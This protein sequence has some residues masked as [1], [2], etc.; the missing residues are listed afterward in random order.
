MFRIAVLTVLS[1]FGALAAS[2][3]TLSV[4]PYPATQ[5][6]E[7]K[8][9]VP[10]KFEGSKKAVLTITSPCGKKEK[11][12]VTI[13]SGKAFFN[14]KPAATG[15]YTME[16]KGADIA[17]KREVPA[18][19]RKMYFYGWVVPRTA[20]ELAKVPV[21]GSCA[22][23]VGGNKEK[24]D[25]YRSYGCTP[26][27]FVSFRAAQINLKTPVDKMVDKMVEKWRKPLEKVL[28]VSG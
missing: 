22:I 6:I 3:A 20:P 10:D 4:Y 15:Y 26:L 21:L 5:D 8:L 28:T 13:E 18:V 16:L 2:A 17:A 19:W 24:F 14:W 11:H 27:A 9:I 7:S 1:L 23:I 12:D 25:E